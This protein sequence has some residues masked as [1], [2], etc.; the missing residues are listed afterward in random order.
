V[1][2]GGD[3]EVI[4]PKQGLSSTGLQFKP[5]AFGLTS[6]T[7]TATTTIARKNTFFISFSLVSHLFL[8]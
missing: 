4:A 1:L 8:S 3:E 5:S 2:D 6:I 7:T